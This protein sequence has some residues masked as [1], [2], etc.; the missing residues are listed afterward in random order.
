MMK[1]T[2]T[3]EMIFALQVALD[4]LSNSAEWTNYLTDEENIEAAK[5]IAQLRSKILNN[6]NK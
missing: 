6:K 2:L 5:G 3:P 4:E 1:V